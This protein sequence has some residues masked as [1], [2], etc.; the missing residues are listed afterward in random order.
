MKNNSKN[1][2]PLQIAIL[3]KER[4]FT[5]YDVKKS[6]VTYDYYVL[7]QGI[8]NGNCLKS[9]K[10]IAKIK[11]AKPDAK[12]L[13]FIKE[14]IYAP[15]YDELQ[16]WLRTTKFLHIAIYPYVKNWSYSIYDLDKDTVTKESFL[17]SSY[18]EMLNAALQKTLNLC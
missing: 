6:I 16:Y 9:K 13:D 15:T 12:F 8:L 11:E 2:V 7:P 17:Y 18:T 1:L 3:A 14:V 10:E 4:G 5:Q